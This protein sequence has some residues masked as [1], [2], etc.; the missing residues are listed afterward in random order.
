MEFSILSLDSSEVQGFPWRNGL[1]ELIQLQ[2]ELDNE[3][4]EIIA[5]MKLNFPTEA[6]W[7]ANEK[8][9]QG[10]VANALPQEDKQLL[11]E[12]E[13]LRGKR[14]KTSDEEA[15]MKQRKNIQNKVYRWVDRVKKQM[16][17]VEYTETQPRAKK[18][19]EVTVDVDKDIAK[20]VKY[21]QR[22]SQ[23]YKEKQEI[24]GDDL[25]IDSLVLGQ[26]FRP[27]I[28][29]DIAVDDSSPVAV[30]EPQAMVAEEQASIQMPVAPP[31]SSTPPVSSPGVATQRTQTSGKR[32]YS[33]KDLKE[34]NEKVQNMS[35]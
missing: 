26:L 33:I 32:A 35:L 2:N 29:A 16:H 20:L 12:T 14:G 13:L 10:I 19:K 8:K 6:Q 30:G 31:I 17:Y 28:V 9:I 3:L 7:E 5:Q 27:R 1:V 11:Q 22:M 4:V 21:I 15:K 23:S 18:T 24:F 34:L 25:T